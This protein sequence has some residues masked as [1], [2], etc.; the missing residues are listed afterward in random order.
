MVSS[1]KL[2]L[3][4]QWLI[5]PPFDVAWNATHAISNQVNS[6]FNLFD[7]WDFRPTATWNSQQ[8]LLSQFSNPV[9]Q[10]GHTYGFTSVWNRK[11]FTIPFINFSLDSAQFQF[12]ETESL[13]YD[14][15]GLQPPDQIP[16]Q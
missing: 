8:S 14:S 1:R 16:H 15:S 2:Q 3:D 9:E 13:Q 12:T 6:S 5:N 11:I 10:D 7:F 4:E